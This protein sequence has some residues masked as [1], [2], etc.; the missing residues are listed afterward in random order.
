MV[1]RIFFT[2][3][4]KLH[5]SWYLSAAFQSSIGCFK[6]W[7]PTLC[8]V[9]LVL[10]CWPDYLLLPTFIIFAFG[11]FNCWMHFGLCHALFSCN[12]FSTESVFC[13]SACFLFSNLTYTSPLISDT[14]WCCSPWKMITTSSFWLHYLFFILSMVYVYM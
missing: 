13:E 7:P 1:P 14:M 9:V 6:V 10:H 8:V 4:S 2:S 5:S 11:S 12:S 3:F